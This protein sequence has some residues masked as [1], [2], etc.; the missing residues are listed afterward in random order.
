VNTLAGRLSGAKRKDLDALGDDEGR[1]E[2]DT[3]LAD[4]LTV[5]LFVARQARH[6]IRGSGPRDRPEMF[7][8]LV[9]RHADT[10]VGNG[11]GP[12]PAVEVDPD[13]QFTAFG[14][15]LRP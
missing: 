8:G 4:Q 12:R 3:E 11:D 1:I 9:T 7:D 5:P 15:Q 14:S 6:E 2:S 13:G 10:V